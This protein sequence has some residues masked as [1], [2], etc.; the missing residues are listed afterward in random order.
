MVG[1]DGA[2][3]VTQRAVAAEAGLPASAVYYYYFATIDDLVAAVL[4]DVNDRYLAAFDALPDGPDAVAAFAALVEEGART[5]R[6]EVLAE[7]ELWL[8]S[9]RRPALRPELE[10]WDAGLRAAAVDRPRRGG[11]GGRPGARPVRPRPDRTR[12]GGPDRGAAPR[13]G[14]VLG[15]GSLS[16]PCATMER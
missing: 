5:G 6:D 8:L 13:D 9:A 10:R 11:G 15:P 14:A 7:V 12:G 16:G 1:R 4:T 3:G 2:A